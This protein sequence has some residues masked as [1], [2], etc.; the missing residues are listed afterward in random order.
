MAVVAQNGGPVG[1]GIWQACTGRMLACEDYCEFQIIFRHFLVVIV[2]VNTGIGKTKSVVR[3][4]V[5][6]I[7]HCF[8]FWF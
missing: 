2:D 4:F 8:W 1:G 5:R 3:V 7:L 6:L